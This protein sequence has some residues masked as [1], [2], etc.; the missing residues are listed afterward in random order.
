M[1]NQINYGL[2]TNNTRS[3]SDSQRS[4]PGFSFIPKAHMRH[5]D[6]LE[7]EVQ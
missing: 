2:Q 7:E 3:G 4:E 6:H 1:I 5:S